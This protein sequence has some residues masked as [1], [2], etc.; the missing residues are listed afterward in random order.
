MLSSVVGTAFDMITIHGDAWALGWRDQQGLKVTS[1]SP[2][3]AYLANAD[4]RYAIRLDM[5]AASLK[6]IPFQLRCRVAN[7]ALFRFI[8]FGWFPYRE[9]CKITP[10]SRSDAH[11]PVLDLVAAES[12][13]VS[14]T[15]STRFTD[16]IPL[17]RS[18]PPSSGSR[19]FHESLAIHNIPHDQRRSCS[20]CRTARARLGVDHQTGQGVL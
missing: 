13:L 17:R 14:R 12:L 7:N 6:R 1:R 2:T 20:L 5:V 18:L 19:L 3:M 10:C 8:L 16:D 15:Q 4:P 9:S 11:H